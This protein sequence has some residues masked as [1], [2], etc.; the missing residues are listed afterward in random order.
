MMVWRARPISATLGLLLCCGIPEY[1]AAQ[2]ESADTKRLPEWLKLGAELRTRTE[3]EQ[4][5]SA[6]QSRHELEFYTRSRVYAQLRPVRWVRLNLQVQDSRVVVRRAGEVSEAHENLLDAQYAYVEL[7]LEENGRWMVRL[8]RQPLELGDG[9]LIGADNFWDNRARSFEGIRAT[10]NHRSLSWDVFLVTPTTVLARRLDPRGASARLSGVAASWHRA[11]V[12][13]QPYLLLH[14]SRAGGLS[15][16][17]GPGLR[18]NAAFGLGWSGG[19]EMVLE[20]GRSQGLQVAAW[21]GHWEIS[22][23]LAQGAN[24]PKFTVGYSFASGRDG[25][26]QRVNTFDDLYPAGY[27]SCG[28]IEPFPWR[29]IKDLSGALEWQ[30]TTN[31][32]VTAEVHRYSRATTRDGIYVDGGPPVASANTSPAK[33]GFRLNGS[34][35]RSL[36]AHAALAAGYVWFPAAASV[37]DSG[38]EHGHGFFLSFTVRI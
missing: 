26:D 27:N 4:V 19:T 32:R 36:N 9:R 1:L 5:D 15:M 18:M 37:V 31:W 29:N 6:G 35:H 2:D 13:F 20:R 14:Q 38:V 21:A 7:G 3:Y 8:G 33:L 11:D 16:L 34:V 28:F 10:L 17:W 22:H 23:A 24:A 12:S 30:R 25:N